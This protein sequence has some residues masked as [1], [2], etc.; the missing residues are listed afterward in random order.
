MKL[1]KRINLMFGEER[2]ALYDVEIQHLMDRGYD[3]K[4]INAFLE[5]YALTIGVFDILSMFTRSKLSV[6][7]LEK[8]LSFLF[9]RHKMITETLAKHLEP[10]CRIL[11]VGCGRGLVTCSLALKNFE[12]HGVDI[13][14]DALEIANKL[15]HKL[16]CRPTFHLIEGN[17]LPF[18]DS[19]FDAA[20]CVWTL[21]EIPQDQIQ[22]I[23]KELHRVLR[24]MGNVLI[25]DQEGV[26]SFEIIKTSMSQSGFKLG[27][28][29]SLSTVYDHGRASQALLLKCVKE[30]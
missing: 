7:D 11:D 28:E 23:S 2:A 22:K 6:N 21:H 10:N 16:G 15:A 26:A 24:K 19:Y 1:T 14:V 20:F 5:N 9:S 4:D 27:L 13:S 17:D 25:I 30:P 18:A 12:V 3:E 29:K 8:S